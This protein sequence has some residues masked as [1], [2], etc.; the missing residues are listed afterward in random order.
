MHS[1]QY[2][3]SMVRAI[4]RVLPGPSKIVFG[5]PGTATGMSFRTTAGS[6][7][8]CG[9]AVVVVASLDGDSTERGL[10]LL[11]SALMP[12]EQP[13]TV[14]DAPKANICRNLRL[15]S[16]PRWGQPWHAR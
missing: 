2:P 7:A 8:G 4:C 5:A 16:S 15:P 9:A 3:S 10:T 11:A 1:E 6:G 14:N 12:D 13:A